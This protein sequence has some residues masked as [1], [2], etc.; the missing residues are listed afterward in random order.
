[1]F[2]FIKFIL[3]T[4]IEKNDMKIEERKKK[5]YLRAINEDLIDKLNAKDELIRKMNLKNMKYI[6]TQRISNRKNI[7]LIKIIY[8]LKIIIEIMK[9]KIL[10]IL[11]KTPRPIKH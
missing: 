10:K 11:D 6:R 1:M 8:I 3:K 4:I 5:L 7:R 9:E 2:K